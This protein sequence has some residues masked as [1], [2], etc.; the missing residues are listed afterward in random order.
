TIK[1]HAAHTR[2]RAEGDELRPQ[3]LKVALTEIEFL[4]RQHH[5]TAAFR[6]FIGERRNL[7]SIRELIGC[8]ALCR[9]KVGCLPVPERDR[10]GLTQQHYTPTARSLSCAS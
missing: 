8:D 7:G 9:D 2:L 3:L 1:I 6:R 10:A 4:L 5:N